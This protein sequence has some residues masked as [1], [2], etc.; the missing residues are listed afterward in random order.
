MDSVDLPGC[1]PRAELGIA[2]V[3]RSSDAVTV[4]VRG[5]IDMDN[6]EHLR[7]VLLG[8]LEAAPKV[9]CVDMSGVT[10]LGSVGLRVLVECHTTAQDRARQLVLEDVREWERRVIAM[11]GLDELFEFRGS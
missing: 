8:V 3:G 9:L 1:C 6:G 5:E 2:V 10:F 7:H 4:A 11:A